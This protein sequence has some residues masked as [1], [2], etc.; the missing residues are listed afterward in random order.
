MRMRAVQWQALRLLPQ[1]SVSARCRVIAGRRFPSRPR[2]FHRS[3]VACTVPDGHSDKTDP[4][5]THEPDEDLPISPQEPMAS[6]D[7]AEN[8]E[9]LDT[10]PPGRMQR[11]K[12]RQGNYGSAARRSVRNRKPREIPAV[13]LPSWFSQ[14]S[15][16]LKEELQTPT[17]PVLLYK[18][19]ANKQLDS[20]AKHSPTRYNL[21][22]DI[23]K[24]ILSTIR[25]GLALP[26]P[27]FADDFPAT[28]AHV[29]LQCPKDGGI[30]FLDS[31]VEKAA[32]A[33]N[34]DLIRL[35]AQ[36]LAE[37]GGDYIGE[38]QDPGSHSIRSLSY[39]VQQVAAHQKAREMEE[40]EE[41]EG[42]EEEG[43]E[44]EDT[45][46]RGASS[47]FQVPTI[48][49]F[50]AIPIGTFNGNLEDFFKAGKLF[51]GNLISNSA[52]SNGTPP[53]YSRSGIPSSEQWSDMK[54]SLLLEA[55][56]DAGLEKRK[57]LKQGDEPNATDSQGTPAQ[58]PDGESLHDALRAP[59][60]TIVMLRDYKEI[61]ATS[62]GER[63]L[64]RL[65]DI[66]RRRRKEGQRIVL[67]GTVSSADLM[68]SLSKSA[69]RNLQSEYED[70]LSRTIIVTPPRTLTQDGVFAEDGCRRI[71]EIN[72]RHLRDMVRRRSRGDE[73]SIPSAT[74][75]DWRLDSSLEFASG[76]SDSVWSFDRVH[77]VAV[78]ALGCKTKGGTLTPEDVGRALELL[79]A[80]DDVKFQWVNEEKRKST[81]GASLRGPSVIT[82]PL[83]ES[84]EKMKQLRKTCNDHEKKLLGGVVNPG[85]NSSSLL[86]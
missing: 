33:L 9:T 29:I 48:S 83:I 71:R 86:Y 12:E 25:A 36:D 84:E 57:A 46:S 61:S 7:V 63:V 72:M 56:V 3:A 58:A 20:G 66:I 50:S 78:N 70:G 75:D 60:S 18:E 26:N 21:H 55:L 28:K 10:L 27:S 64:G 79:G 1:L 19:P 40:A 43:E 30:F 51:T 59:W 2:A 67:V 52:R 24:E 81:G 62:Q 69:V 4:I 74:Q 42:L 35:D 32:S 85:M 54:L 45:P 73:Q 15:V 53:Q 31:I 11:P 37:I 39:N 16:R 6:A 68:P 82:S 17:D 22:E 14:N 23:W 34:A 80:S 5:L 47:H 41:D 65:L 76:L 8:D 38:D 44:E 49:K 13:E 77:R